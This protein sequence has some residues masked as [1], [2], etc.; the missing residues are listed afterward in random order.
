[1]ILEKIVQYVYMNKKLQTVAH[2]WIF[3]CEKVSSDDINWP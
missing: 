1:M 2:K 3:L